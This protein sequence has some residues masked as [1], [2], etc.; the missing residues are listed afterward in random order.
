MAVV[1]IPNLPIATSLT[2]SEELEI[3]QSGE[4]KRTTSQSIA[5]L[6]P[7]MTFPGYWA[8]YY[9]S[10]SQT[11]PSGG[12]VNKATFNNA[13]GTYGISLVSNTRI[14]FPN[15]GVYAINIVAQIDKTDSGVDQVDIWLMKNNANI[16][17]TN[18]RVTLSAA[19]DKTVFTGSYIQ[20]LNANDYVEV[21]WLSADIDL[22]LYAEAAAGLLPATPSIIANVQLIREL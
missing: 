22:L 3:V 9:S 21:A 18:R 15:A 1:Q 2:G 7:D 19:G 16:A 13:F 10:V 5:N 20:S 11:N 12:A 8:S 14:T 17:A 6:A 4:S